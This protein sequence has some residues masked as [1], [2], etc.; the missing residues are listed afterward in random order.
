MRDSCAKDIHFNTC[1][2]YCQGELCNDAIGV[3]DVAKEQS[4]DNKSRKE[5]KKKITKEVTS[6]RRNTYFDRP[7]MTPARRRPGIGSPYRK[8]SQSAARIN[9]CG[10]LLMIYLY[11]G[12]LW[13]RDETIE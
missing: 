12:T 1:F 11:F 2:M 9:S 10:P 8:G 4:L 7:D 6:N 3:V 13:L 5:K